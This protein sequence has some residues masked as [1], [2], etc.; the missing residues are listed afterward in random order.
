MD[1]G[2]GGIVLPDQST[3]RVVAGYRAGR[4]RGCHLPVGIADQAADRIDAGHVAGCIDGIETV[5]LLDP[6]EAAGVVTAARHIASRE[7]VD[8]DR[9]VIPTDE[10]ADTVAGACDRR[11]A[12]TYTAGVDHPVVFADE[13]ADPRGSTNGAGRRAAADRAGIGKADEAAGVILSLHRARCRASG[14]GTVG[15]TDKAAGEVARS[16]DGS[17]GRRV[18][19]RVVGSTG[20]PAGVGATRYRR[21][22]EGV[23]D[24]SITPAR[25][26]TCIGLAGNDAGHRHV[27]NRTGAGGVCSDA[28]NVTGAV[29]VDT[30]QCQIGHRT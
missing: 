10:T 9:A 27:G 18:R 30:A 2:D 12:R 29:Q 17:G 11:G 1:V 7:L 4:I 16:V 24:R 25:H 21:A 19:D 13:A 20:Q 14:D 3:D 28:A 6:D 5:A 23:A 8:P 22:G 15:K 26:T